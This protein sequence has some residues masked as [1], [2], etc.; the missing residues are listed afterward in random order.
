MKRYLVLLSTK[1]SLRFIPEE[2]IY[3]FNIDKTTI[4]F[5]RIKDEHDRTISGDDYGWMIEVKLDAENIDEAIDRALELSEFFLSAFCLETGTEIYPS[6]RI[7]AYDITEVVE[8]RVFRQYFRNLPYSSSPTQVT[9]SSFNEQ[10]YRIFTLE[11]EYRNRIYRAIRWFRKGILGN[12]PID[13]FI[14]FWHGLETL[15]SPLAKF[16]GC[17]KSIEKEIEIKCPVCGEKYKNTITT[18]GGIEALYDDIGIEVTT[19]KKINEVRNAISHGFENLSEI[20]AIA[21]ELLPS[22]AEI[23]HHGIAKVLDMSF[24]DSLYENLKRVAPIKPGDFNYIESYINE[25]K[26]SE[27]GVGGYY[28]F[29]THESNVI[30]TD[31]GFEIQSKFQSHVGC[32]STI[33]ATGTSGKNI[34]IKIQDIL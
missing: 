27:I 16:F 2:A 33:Y 21:L 29:Y 9:F 20:Y 17:E 24:D 13:Q 15:N 14:F 12:D 11:S 19:R 31:K 8:K 32:E 1:T 22:M 7:L 6:N 18:K 30:P 34:N 4:S 10:A 23:S 26:L 28:P 3:S 5:Q 25:Q